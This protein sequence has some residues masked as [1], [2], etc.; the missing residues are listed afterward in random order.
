MQKQ[1][2]TQFGKRLT[3]LV[4]PYVILAIVNLSVFY[5]YYELACNWSDFCEMR[6]SLF[7]FEFPAFFLL[8]LIFY[9]PGQRVTRNV[10]ASMAA[11]LPLLAY[12]VIFDVF[13]NFRHSALRFSD[14]REMRALL[15]ISPTM[16]MG[17]IATTLAAISPSLIL[18]AKYLKRKGIF[19]FA[20][21][22]RSVITSDCLPYFYHRFCSALSR[23][24]SEI[25]RM[26]GL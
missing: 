23:Q 14:I 25:C 3:N 21:I 20:V 13:Y 7:S 15:N 11:I 17:L 6:G 19:S 8:S 16:F 9:V 10:L 4:L 18:L 2:F 1:Y 22:M 5:G 26:V 24:V 12:Y